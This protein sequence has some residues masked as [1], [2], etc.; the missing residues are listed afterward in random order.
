MNYG[1]SHGPSSSSKHTLVINYSQSVHRTAKHI[2]I[3]PEAINCI[4][5]SLSLYAS[6]PCLTHLTSK[7][8]PTMTVSTFFL[9]LSVWFARSSHTLQWRIRSRCNFFF[10]RVLLSVF[11][12]EVHPSLEAPGSECGEAG[13]YFSLFVAPGSDVRVQ[14]EHSNVCVSVNQNLSRQDSCKNIPPEYWFNK[15][16]WNDMHY[17]CE[18]QYILWISI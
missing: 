3:L 8:I 13:I 18:I 9:I 5:P 2:W 16:R 1:E 11:T 4:S 6:L 10:F 17:K 12:V 14:I 15:N 7:C